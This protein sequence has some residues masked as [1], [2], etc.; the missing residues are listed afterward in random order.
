MGKSGNKKFLNTGAQK[1]KL[2]SQDQHI[3]ALELRKQGYSY[4]D[5]AKAC[6]YASRGAAHNAVSSALKQTLREPADELRTLELE[7]LDK[8][9]RAMQPALDQGDTK[10]AAC[11]IR[12]ME[13]RAKLLGLDAAIKVEAGMGQEA[14]NAV[15]ALLG[16]TSP[17][18]A[19]EPAPHHSHALE[20]LEEAGNDLQDSLNRAQLH[21]D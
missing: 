8:I 13:R 9:I 2:Q 19:P 11:I 18:P 20:L 10:A 15:Q 17:A 7:R 5:I 14:V 1:Q 6:G 16:V 3:K 21:I 12:V 4:E